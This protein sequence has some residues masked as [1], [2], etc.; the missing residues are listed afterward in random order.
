[1]QGAMSRPIHDLVLMSHLVRI[2]GRQGDQ[3]APGYNGDAGHPGQ[4]G[5]KGGKGVVGLKVSFSILL[6]NNHGIWSVQ[7]NMLEVQVP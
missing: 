1:M 2:Q 3:G 4:Q 5:R 6:C 7:G